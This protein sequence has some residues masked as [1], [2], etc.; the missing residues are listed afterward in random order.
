MKIAFSPCPNDTFAFDAWIHGK[1]TSTIKPEPIVADIQQLNAWAYQALY[2]VTKVSCFTLGKIT[3]KYA[4][5]PSGAAICNAGP[6]IIAKEPFPISELSKKRI[7]VPGLD[8]T[9]YLLLRTLCPEPKEIGICRY[10]EITAKLEANEADCGLII[11]ETRFCFE[12]AG[13]V[14]LCDLGQLFKKNFDC[15]VPLGVVVAKKEA[16]KE[17]ARAL[18]ESIAYAFNNPQSSL[19]YVR[20]L[21]QEKDNTIIQQHIQ[22]YVNND[23]LQISEEGLRA[24]HTLFQLA[25]DQKLLPREALKFYETDHFCYH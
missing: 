12:Q 8:T 15:A 10:D 17:A 19:D 3:Q 18:K 4:L 13:F 14:E 20:R 5:L 6:K 1:I 9:A 21:S 22:T 7:L 25:V 16:Y 23:T 2:P 24:I 11:H